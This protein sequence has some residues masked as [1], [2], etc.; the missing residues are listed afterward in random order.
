MSA[1]VR[2]LGKLVQPR[3]TKVAPSDYPDLPY[4]GLEHI[5]AQTTRRLGSVPASEMRSAANR[6]QP[7]DVL[8]SRLRPYLNKV[9][10]ADCEGLCSAEF[11]VLPGN[12]EVDSDYLRYRLNAHDF[13][14]FATRLNAG[15]RPRVDF[16]QISVF[17]TWVPNSLKDQRQIVAEIEKQFSRLEEGVGALKRVQAN[18]KRY[19]AAVLKAACEGRLVPTEAEL[20]KSR[21][22]VP[23]L[24]SGGKRQDAASTFES[25]AE[26]LARIL[27][28][29][30]KNWQG[31]GKY[32]ETTSPDTSNLG[33]L[34]E[35]WAL[36][37]FDQVCGAVSDGRKKLPKSDY[38]P[39]GKY[40]VIDQGESQIGG[41]SNDISLVYDGMLPVVVFGDHTRRFK[42]VQEKF[43]VGAD[44]VKLIGISKAWDP[45]FLW[46]QFQQ[47]DF[48]DRGYS[49]HFQ[50]LRKAPLL[51]PP[52]AEQ[53]RI[54][55]E[56]ER[57]LS[58][59]EELEAVVAANLQRA[60]R[61]RQSILQKA[62]AGELA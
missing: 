8:Y 4:I 27:A 2:P 22:G 55:A 46:F 44:G 52:I 38:L 25:G 54:V 34:P 60:A 53:S 21:S 31:R 33:K 62:F 51:L 30:R 35:G 26:L 49:R 61:L 1:G 57:R 41:Y 16:D 14:S 59:V 19:R 50:F 12:N 45:M 5:E 17:E 23:P 11:I 3:R 39:S 7:G 40:A 48:E 10:R 36:V 13:V 15:D 18:L 32:K 47:L 28:E 9:W 24:G 43:I 58:V 20:C 6:F 29:R 42:L 37:A 56:V